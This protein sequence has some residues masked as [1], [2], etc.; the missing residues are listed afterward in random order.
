MRFGV[1]V[2]ELMEAYPERSF[3]VVELVRYATRGRPLSP[4]ERE[5][6]RKAV[7][8]LLDALIAS[9]FV[10]ISRPASASGSAAEYSM[11]RFRDICPPKAGQEAGQYVRALAP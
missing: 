6:A 2:M 9:G 1:E 3:R 4:S 5:A 11:S 8:R 7:K 10:V